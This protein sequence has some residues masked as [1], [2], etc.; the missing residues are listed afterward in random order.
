LKPRAPTPGLDVPAWISQATTAD[1]RTYAWID[2]P[3][4]LAHLHAGQPR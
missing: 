1:G 3:A 4:M 2:V